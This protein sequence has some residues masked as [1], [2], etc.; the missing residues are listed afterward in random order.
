MEDIL[1]A[2]VVTSNQLVIWQ[3][4]RL[5]GINDPIPG[6]GRLAA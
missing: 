2:P 1:D 4:L 6:L 3:A 5:A